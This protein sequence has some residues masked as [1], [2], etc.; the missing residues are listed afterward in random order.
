M[1]LMTRSNVRPIGI[2]ALSLFFW[3]GTLASGLS[4]VSLLFPGSFLEP[5]W[6]LNP[7]AREGFAAIGAWAVLLMFVVCLA[8]IAAA[9]GLWRGARWG[10]ITAVV[11][12]SVNLIGDIAN[13]VTGTEAKA[14]IGVPI[15]TGLIVYLMTKRVR[16]FFGESSKG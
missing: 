8:C 5:M 16:A 14:L 2:T 15:A 12:L 1:P 11:M 6:R 3:F 9:T 4:F 10:C 13:V 7:H